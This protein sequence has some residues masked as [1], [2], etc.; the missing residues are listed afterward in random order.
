ME[1]L[2]PGEKVKRLRKDIGLK[3]EELTD[4]QI[5]RSLISMIENGKRILSP[6]VAKIIAK[7]LSVYY[8]H[9]GR[10]ITPEYLLE[11]KEEQVKRNIE[12]QLSSIDLLLSQRQRIEYNHIQDIFEVILSMAQDWS[13]KDYYSKA[14]VR[15]GDFYYQTTKYNIALMD[16]YSGIEYYIE[17]KNHQE[18]SRIYNKIANCYLMQSYFDEALLYY[19]R[20]ASIAIEHNIPNQSRIKALTLYNRIICYRKAKK[21]DLVFQSI[22]CFNQLQNIEEDL[23][24]KV[25]LMEANT[26]RDLDNHEKAEKI[27]EKLL[28]KEKKL[29][30]D[31]LAHIYINLS[32]LHCKLGN[33]EEALDFAYKG[34]SMINQLD[35]V[36]PVSLWVELAE[37]FRSL[38]E[39]DSCLELLKEASILTEEASQFESSIHIQLLLSDFYRVQRQDLQQTE[40]HLIKA[41]EMVNKHCIVSKYQE[42]N[43][44]IACYYLDTNQFQLCKD[45]MNLIG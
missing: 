39:G 13:M 2:N 43:F 35:P 41:Q 38:N 30:V 4:D 1:I 18:V 45:Y 15:R 31:T 33:R 36:F 20:A 5:T 44:K 23:F 40:A 29:Q 28:L 3:Q 16:F 12:T 22:H 11:S 34:R 27:Y 26:Y 8:K 25:M 17:T 24:D 32:V 14:L 9:M 10:T 21:F 6:Q 42:I 19:H 37:C 7:R